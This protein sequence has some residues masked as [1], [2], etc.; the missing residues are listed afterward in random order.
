MDLLSSDKIVFYLNNGDSYMG[1][2]F[3]LQTRTPG[4]NW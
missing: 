2:K 1:I 4:A 3:N